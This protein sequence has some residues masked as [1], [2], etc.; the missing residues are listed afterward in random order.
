MK[1]KRRLRTLDISLDDITITNES[2][3]Q[4]NR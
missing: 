1:T 2:P 3:T 4:Q